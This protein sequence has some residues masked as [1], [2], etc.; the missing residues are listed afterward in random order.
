MSKKQYYDANNRLVGTTEIVNGHV[1]ARSPNGTKLAEYDSFTDTTKDAG[2]VK[3][4]KG[5]LV[6]NFFSQDPTLKV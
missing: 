6:T 2:G 4:G 3:F 1:I 5:N